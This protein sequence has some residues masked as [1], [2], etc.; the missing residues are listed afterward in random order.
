MRSK[1]IEKRFGNRDKSR[2][3]TAIP[4]VGM[5]SVH[6]APRSVFSGMNRIKP[7]FSRGYVSKVQEILFAGKATIPATG[8]HAGPSI[9]RLRSPPLSS[10]ASRLTKSINGRTHGFRI[11]LGKRRRPQ[12]A[13]QILSYSRPDDI[14]ALRRHATEEFVPG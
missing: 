4:S 7:I 10:K 3:A 1:K 5:R 14:E 11:K 8:S 9:Y 12:S 13:P 6:V 2:A